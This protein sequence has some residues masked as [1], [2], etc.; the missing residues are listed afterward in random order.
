MGDEVAGL[1]GRS[2]IMTVAADGPCVV[3]GRTPSERV[4]TRRILEEDRLAVLA[5]LRALNR[6]VSPS[7]L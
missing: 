1:R 3:T 2:E 6:T 5:E 4:T 7:M